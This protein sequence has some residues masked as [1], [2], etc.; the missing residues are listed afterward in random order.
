MNF[1]LVIMNK[2]IL[3]FFLGFYLLIFHNK[4][5]AG[6]QSSEWLGTYYDTSTKWVYKQ[7]HGW[8][9]FYNNM[10]SNIDALGFW[11]WNDSWKWSRISLFPWVWSHSEGGWKFFSTSNNTWIYPKEFSIDNFQILIGGKI[12]SIPSGWIAVKSS[13]SSDA[14]FILSADDGDAHM[15]FYSYDDVDLSTNF[16]RWN[17]QFI[18]SNVLENSEVN[19]NSTN[20][21]FVSLEGTYLASKPFGFKIQREDFALFGINVMSD[22]SSIAIKVTGRKNVTQERIDL[23]KVMIMNALAN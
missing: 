17:N 14:E 6:W 11:Y 5:Y 21:N 15:F 18:E 9:Y 10:P 23:L 16:D 19:I 4:S 7:D 12:F 8:M 1:L 22:S 3:L 20:V 13:Y 2:K